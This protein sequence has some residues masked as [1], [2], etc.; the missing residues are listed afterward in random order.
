MATKWLA[1]AS[2]NA[3]FALIK[4][5]RSWSLKDDCMAIRCVARTLG[6]LL[7]C[8]RRAKLPA[9]ATLDA[10]TPQTD[11]NRPRATQK[12]P[13][14][15]SPGATQAAMVHQKTREPKEK[16]THN[17]NANV[18]HT[19]TSKKHNPSPGGNVTYTQYIWQS[20]KG[21]P[22]KNAKEKPQQN[23]HKTSN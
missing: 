22:K 1:T 13:T 9:K 8:Q 14:Q 23:T 19:A 2:Q 10:V 18:S 21:P 7:L 6:H 12:P 16:N 4:G 5:G 15:S 20:K 17:S 11:R 3:A